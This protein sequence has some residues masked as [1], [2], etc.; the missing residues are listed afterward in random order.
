MK[1]PYH[2]TLAD[3]RKAKQRVLLH[4]SD[5]PI[6][7]AITRCVCVLGKKRRGLGISDNLLGLMAR[8]D[9]GLADEIRRL[10]QG[11]ATVILR[12]VMGQ[13][14]IELFGAVLAVKA[15]EPPTDDTAEEVTP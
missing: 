7:A 10:K 5:R 2:F 3:F 14:E 6:Y 15:A 4:F 1:H 12:E 13:F 8:K 9:A 11:D